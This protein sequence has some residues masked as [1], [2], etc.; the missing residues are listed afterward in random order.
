MKKWAPFVWL[1]FVAVA[2]TVLW[3]RLQDVRF[4]D[5]SAQLRSL[6]ASTLGLGIG[7]CALAY[8]L[9]GVYEGFALR[10]VT[11][12]RHFWLPF[13]TAVIANPIGRAVGVAMV[14]GGALRYRFYSAAGFSIKQSAGI[15]VM[16]AMPYLLGV[17]WMAG[18]SLLVHSEQAARALRLPPGVVVALGC[19]ALAATW[20]WY[21]IVKWR[22]RPIRVANTDVRLPDLR[23]S[24]LQTLFG[25]AQISCLT[26]I[27]YL[28]MPSELQLSWPQFVAIYCIAFVAGQLS[29]VPAGLGVLEAALLIMLPHVPPAKLLGAVLAYRA[30]FELLPLFVALLLWFAYEVTH[31]H[32][33]VKKRFRSA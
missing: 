24:L 11:G 6:P 14:S 23:H 12:E 28:F 29:N 3:D 10:W 21:G 18:G 4:A 17:G 9:V 32:G 5:I 13:R 7:L 27:L 1:A 26:G 33:I 30:V 31:E 19:S 20:I 15:I 25:I 8:S 2:G 22:A 16:M